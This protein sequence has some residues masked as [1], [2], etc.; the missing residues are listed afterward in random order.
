MFRRSTTLLAVLAFGASA[1]TVSAQPAPAT[2]PSPAPAPTPA[3]TPDAKAPTPAA[4]AP[5]T[6]SK[7]PTDADM[8]KAARTNERPWAV[9]I[10]AESQKMALVLFTEGNTLLGGALFVRAVEK[11]REALT[12]WDHP[13]IHYNLALALVN[14]DQPVE[15]DAALDKAMAY[16]EAPIDKDKFERAKGYKVLIA[17]QI[18]TVSYTVD[19]PGARVTFDGREVLIGPGTWTSR[20]RAGEH[21]VAAAA[22][23]YLPVQFSQKLAGGESANLI[24]RL[25]TD[26]EVTRYRRRFP[27]WLPW[28]VTGVGAVVAGVGGLLHQQAISG[29]AR[30]DDEIAAC[31]QANGGLGCAS[32]PPEIS[33]ERRTAETRQLLGI[34]GYVLGG[35][36]LA[37]GVTM[38]LLNRPSAYRIDPN[39]EV[40]PLA[41]RPILTPELVGLAAVGR[42]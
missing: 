29:F 15:M 22:E 34:S 1:S 27:T 33:D 18:A 38:V 9:G 5:G 14:L 20:V 39:A 37:A 16:G 31:A 42:F 26:A 2:T 28:A 36:V 21:A 12:H 19:V 23:G 11:Y 32:P 8:A 40:L 24:L 3:P 13:A 17:K 10:S 6:P 25:Y 4:P 41:A 30:Y 7:P 35:A